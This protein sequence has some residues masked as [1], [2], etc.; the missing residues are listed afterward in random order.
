VLFQQENEV[1]SDVMDFKQDFFKGGY[2]ANKFPKRVDFTTDNLA[3]LKEV[4]VARQ[5]GD[6]IFID[7]LNGK[8]TYRIVDRPETFWLVAERIACTKI[9]KDSTAQ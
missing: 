3:L 8:A 4:G 9:S 7:C 2:V 6:D 1:K 5:E